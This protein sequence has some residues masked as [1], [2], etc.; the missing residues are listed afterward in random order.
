MIDRYAQDREPEAYVNGG[1]ECDQLG[2]DMT[3]VV[4]LRDDQVKLTL[5]RTIEYRI[6]R[7]RPGYGDALAAGS[8]D[9]RFD[10]FDLVGAE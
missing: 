7:N 3:L 10:A 6:A 8:F 1:I 5:Q 4:I 9:S 2:R